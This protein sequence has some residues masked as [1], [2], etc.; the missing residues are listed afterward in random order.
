MLDWNLNQP[1]RGNPPNFMDFLTNRY[2]ITDSPK[3]RRHHI[4]SL[5]LTTGLYIAGVH[6][7]TVERMLN[8]QEFF[9]PSNRLPDV[10]ACE[11]AEQLLVGYQASTVMALD[12]M[13]Y[14]ESLRDVAISYPT[15]RGILLRKRRSG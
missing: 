3:F 8:W 9:S 6:Q 2:E 10:L 7:L 5:Q 11:S 13:K 12:F 1:F 14:L 15:R 4:S